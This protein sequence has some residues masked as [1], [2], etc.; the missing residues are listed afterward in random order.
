[1]H[2]AFSWEQAATPPHVPPVH[3]SAPQHSAEDAQELPGAVHAGPHV[4]PLQER[5]LQHSDDAAHAPPDA[6][7]CVGVPPLFGALELHD[8]MSELTSATSSP[9]KRVRRRMPASLANE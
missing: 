1:V 2:A 3:A 7:H 6:T 9:V 4:P 5:A 8:T